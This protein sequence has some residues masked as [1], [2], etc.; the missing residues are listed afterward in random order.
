MEH[1]KRTWWIVPVDDSRG[2]L[3]TL[4]SPF[5]QWKFFDGEITS[6]LFSLLEFLNMRILFPVDDSNRFET[7][8]TNRGSNEGRLIFVIDR[9]LVGH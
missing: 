1:W 8:V 4:V 3:E 7:M 6:S 2:E 5:V 9:S